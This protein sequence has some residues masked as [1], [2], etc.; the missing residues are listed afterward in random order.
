[1]GAL[2]TFSAKFGGA[3]KTPAG[4]GGG[5]G[6]SSLKDFESRFTVAH[7]KNPTTPVGGLDKLDATQLATLGLKSGVASGKT[8]GQLKSEAYLA[9]QKNAPA[10]KPEGAFGN[11]GWGGLLS[12][13]SNVG[14]DAVHLASGV[15]NQGLIQPADTVGHAINHVIQSG[16]ENKQ[17]QQA[18][19][20]LDAQDAQA[21][22]EFKA[23]KINGSRYT[24]LLN[25]HQG[26]RAAVVH[27]YTAQIHA[28]PSGKQA[29][30]ALGNLALT[31][32]TAGTLGGGEAE[33]E[34][35]TKAL[36]PKVIK[37]AA[38]G[39]AYNA[40]TGGLTDLGD[41]KSAGQ[42]AKDI[43]KAALTGAELGA[44]GELAGAAGGALVKGIINHLPGGKVAKAADV[45]AP[46]IDA[47]KAVAKAPDGHVLPTAFSSLVPKLAEGDAKGAPLAAQFVAG[48]TRNLNDVLDQAIKTGGAKDMTAHDQQLLVN[49]LETAPRKGT[50]ATA[51]ANRID[52]AAETANNPEQFRAVVAANKQI[53]DQI[54]VGDLATPGAPKQGYIQNYL[55]RSDTLVD[56]DGNAIVGA[57]A[58]KL[59]P[60]QN[61][62]LVAGID[63]SHAQNRVFATRNAKYNWVGPD[64]Q[65]FVP[66]NTSVLDDIRDGIEG[67]A[68]RHGSGQLLKSLREAH[69][70]QVA[71]GKIGHNAAGTFKGL[72]IPFGDNV[73]MTKDLAKQYNKRATPE[74]SDHALVRGY[75]AANAAIKN[76][77]LGGGLFH[78]V[79]TA[80]SSLGQGV[81]SGHP[82]DALKTIGGAISSK[83]HDAHIAEFKGDA[84]ENADGLSSYQRLHLH[85]GTLD[86]PG[87][88]AD[89]A[90][91][92]FNKIPGFGKA[93][94]EI[95]DSVFQR[96]IPEAKLTIFKNATK[97]LDSNIPADA[98]KMRQ[99]AN[100]VNKLGGINRAVEGLTPGSAKML[101]RALLAT[102]FT[103]GK[104]RTL[105]AALDPVHFNSLEGKIAR[106][107]VVGKTLVS[108]LPGLTALTIAG[109]INWKDPADVARN[110][111]DQIINPNIPLGH[112]GPGTKTN[113]DGTPRVAKLPATF[114]S[115]LGS[116]IAPALDGLNP[117]KLSGV[118]EYAAARLAALPA[119]GEELKN[120]QDFYGQPIYGSGISKGKTALNVANQIAP[121]PTVQASKALTGGSAEESILNVL[122]LRAA[123]DPTSDAAKHSGAVNDLSNV[124]NAVSKQKS[125]VTKQLNAL[126]NQNNYNQYNRVA[127]DWNNSLPGRF[128]AIT[129]KYPQAD[130]SKYPGY[131]SLK[132]SP[133]TSA[134][135]TRA[136]HSAASTNFLKSL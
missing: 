5:S 19:S 82:V 27:N 37:S 56:K 99:A 3:P 88:Q 74:P 136:T 25:D 72:D 33:G 80:T 135:K 95:H 39:A 62:K 69:P 28:A 85:G 8:P 7:L 81:V 12:K 113:P 131:T 108:V 11:T 109:K 49:T 10:I 92:V 122:G 66:K 116:V 41:N 111:R 60:E 77:K 40:T 50:Q 133:K 14:G 78:G 51:N 13:V 21:E 93:V 98:E 117:D 134:A 48:N 103:E 125:A 112:N 90:S 79:T 132:V 102:D 94:G 30:S 76:A 23:G 129:D 130:L 114:I 119:L 96:Q 73:S 20:Q 59:D 58:A 84:A 45:V 54:H 34:T 57:D 120:N 15:I 126:A 83:A 22:Q 32:G 31:L 97:G 106:Q 63:R 29:L 107:L 110:V 124:S 115:E 16:S 61:P 2:D 26:Q 52:K 121:I 86:A 91:K 24:A 67:A 105:G 53:Q 18:M 9:T 1:M 65:H 44:G 128:K 127:N 17:T 104:V 4:G 89:V 35:A 100:A 71:V 68:N 43:P 101:S 38:T 70:G 6:A 55:P 64:G 47:G 36:A 118:K 87:I 46:G 42:I 75:D 123:N